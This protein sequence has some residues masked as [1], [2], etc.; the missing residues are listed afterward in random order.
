MF[1]VQQLDT[2]TYQNI[3]I[4]VWSDL[5]ATQQRNSFRPL[6]LRT[7]TWTLSQYK[8]DVLLV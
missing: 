1:F 5:M 3:K 4:D 8:K 2:D 7:G 6:Q